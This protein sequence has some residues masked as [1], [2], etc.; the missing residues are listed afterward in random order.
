MKNLSVRILLVILCVVTVLGSIAVYADGAQ[1]EWRVG[2]DGKERY[3]VGG[4]YVTGE[5]KIGNHTYVFAEDGECLGA[6]D[7]Y[8]NPG[9]PGVMDTQAYKDALTSNGYFMYEPFAAGTK[10]GSVEINAENGMPES[11]KG[12]SSKFS[13][14]GL[15]SVIRASVHTAYKRSEGNFAYSYWHNTDLAKYQAGHKSSGNSSH[16]YMDR[17]GLAAISGS[18]FVLEFEFSVAEL[19]SG[20]AIDLCTVSERG[21]TG[22]TFTGLDGEG[23][24]S[25]NT[26][27]FVYSPKRSNRLIANAYGEFVRLSMAIHPSTNKYDV[28]ANGVLVVKDLVLYDNTTQTPEEFSVEEVRM[29]Q[30]SRGVDNPDKVKICVDNFAFYNASAPLCLSTETPKNGFYEDGSYLRCY[31][32]GAVVTGRQSVTGT[33]FGQTLNNVY[34]V[35]ESGNGAAFIGYKATVINGGVTISSGYVNMNRFEAPKAVDMDGKTFVAWNTGTSVVLPGYTTR[36]A[37]DITV[38]AIGVGFATVKGAA[39]ST[40]KDSS[41][42][43]FAAKITKADYDALTSLGATVEPHIITVPTEVVKAAHGYLSTDHLTIEGMEAPVD[44]VA[45]DWL[46]QNESYYFYGASVSGIEDVLKEYSAIAYL[47]ITI[48]GNEPFDIYA[49]YSEE[50]NSR[51]LYEVASAAYNDR[52]T[53]KADGAYTKLVSS[54]GVRTYSPY[55]SSERSRIRAVLDKVV[56]LETEMKGV[57]ASG[58]YYDK[59]Y[60]I[61]YTPS[62]TGYDVSIEPKKR[63]WNASEVVGVMVDGEMLPAESLTVSDKKCSFALD[64]GKIYLYEAK[65]NG[66]SDGSANSWKFI[67]AQTDSSCFTGKVE[68]P[69]TFEGELVESRDQSTVLMWSYTTGSI[70]FQKSAYM[71]SKKEGDVYNLKEWQSLT[72]KVYVPEGYEGCTFYVNVTS[73]NPATD[74]SD[75]YGRTI[76]LSSPGWNDVVIN[77]EALSASRTPRGWDKITNFTFTSTG[78]EQEPDKNTKLLFT[79]FMAYDKSISVASKGVVDGISKDDVAIFTIDG[80]AG[81]INGTTYKIN[82]LNTEV[83]TF[84]QD[85]IIYLPVNVF[86]LSLDDNAVYYDKAGVVSY[87][88]DGDKYVFKAGKTYTVDG[89]AIDLVHPAIAK[90]GGVFISV[91]DAMAIYDYE[92]VN[93]DQMGLIILSNSDKKLDPISESSLIFSCIKDLMYVRPSGDKMYNDLMAHSGGQH[94]YIMVDAQG[95][96]D[97]RY[98]LK[99]DE[100]LQSYVNNI[101]N[102][103][104]VGSNKFKSGTQWFR[105]SDGQRLLSISRDVEDKMLGWCMLYQLGIYEGEEK[106]QLIDRVWQEVEAV[107]NFYDDEY[108]KYSWNPSHYLDTGE[109]SYAMAIAYDWMYDAWTPE[110][111]SIIARAIYEY[112]L[113]TT[114][115]LEGGGA[116]YNL[117]GSGNNWNGVT[118]GGIMSGALAIVNDDYIVSMGLQDEVVKVI[119]A[120]VVGIETGMW[121]YGPD[122]GYEEG[123]GYWSYGTTFCMIHF[124]ALNSACGTNYGL[125]YTPGFKESAYFTT[126]LGSANT[127]WGF[128]DGSSGQSIPSIASWFASISG[129]GNINAIRRQ[130]IEK[131]WCGSGIYDIMF[132]NPHI[133]KNSVD[134][135]LD[136]Y[137]SLDTIMTFRSSWD[138]SN[139]IFAGLHG[140]DNAASHGDLDTGNFVINVNGVYMIN[141]LGADNYNM[142]GYF[143]SYR[144]SYYRKRTEGQNCI[145]MIGHGEKWDGKTGKPECLLDANGKV[146]ESLDDAVYMLSGGAKYTIKDNGGRGEKVSN[147]AGTVP[148]PAY[149]GQKAGSVSRATAFES[150]IN[151]AYGVVDMAPAYATAKGQMLRGLYMKDNRSTVVLQDEGTFNA[152]QDIWWFAHTQGEVTVSE[153]GKTAFIYRNGIYLYCELV[154]DPTKPCDAKFSVMEWESLDPEYVGD[155]V[156]SKIYTGEIEYA[157]GGQKLTVTA[158][159]TKQFNVAVVFKVVSSPAAAPTVGTTY[160]WTP[161]SQ[162]KAE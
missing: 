102:G 113:Q 2:D 25:V 7:T 127:T 38:D 59:P 4:S 75:Y 1:G 110:Q 129:D 152:Y 31:E 35:F 89:E 111:R 55:K 119:G 112:G 17:S 139:N 142:V 157:R 118:N 121:V 154:V 45:T 42:L 82:P 67:S 144:W 18:D 70:S 93:V 76:T 5:Q 101:K 68:L 106:Q 61:V 28:Y 80:Y 16:T 64:D 9:T 94:P 84:K 69:G 90:D 10:Y 131:G 3:Y 135:T 44:T 95:F 72:F 83:K 148:D 73:E 132:F 19:P 36:I 103:Y 160:A 107:A 133:I 85:D 162:W 125:Y 88:Y 150:G 158:T 146:V 81:S 96:A 99:H 56:V 63:G 116:N 134:L 71:S 51:N 26:S 122:G 15:Q 128:H 58:E 108:N 33:F 52:T 86:A 140:G 60:E 11:D 161:I 66:I 23:L 54:S 65:N 97:L 159:N 104:G 79:D 153:D 49:D 48:P 114:S 30:V 117:A 77:K 53:V 100:T 149:Y 87:R 143:G 78:W 92:Y 37:S 155:T 6:L 12:A 109:A 22:E 115:T 141:D 130:G 50:N 126:Y 156:E 41:E 24:L 8:K 123:P 14:S 29:F 120:S 57:N 40:K 13:A 124:A 151:S 46:G 98:Y 91:D 62:E 145:V 137:Y 20:G 39:M 32:N 138:T 21:G 43:I 74:G 136:A 105:R 34:T 47:R 27:G 147:V